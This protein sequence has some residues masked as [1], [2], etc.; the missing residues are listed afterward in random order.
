VPVPRGLPRSAAGFVTG[1]P[2]ADLLDGLDQDR[3]SALAV[4]QLEAALS[5]LDEPEQ[6]P[7]HAHQAAGEARVAVQ[8]L[9]RL[10]AL[11]LAAPDVEG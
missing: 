10:E 11:R 7:W 8:A 9:D 1:V 3:L 6:S 2:V 5:Y 4:E